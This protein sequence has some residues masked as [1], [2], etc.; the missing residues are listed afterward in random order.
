MIKLNN[1]AL[2]LIEKVEKNLKNEFDMIEQIN[3]KNQLKV[4]NAFIDNR[5]EARHFAGTTG[6][7]YDDAGRDAL[8][9]VCAAI[10]HTEDA[11]LSPSLSS[12]T[13]SISQ[14]LLAILRPNDTL[15]C[16]TGIPYD[17]LHDVI[18]GIDG[19]DIGS[20]KDYNIHFDYCDLKD[21][22]IDLVAVE[23]Y[24]K[25]KKP[26]A[27]YLQR[28]RGYCYRDAICIS[29]MREAFN[30]IKSLSPECIIIVDNCYGELTEEYEPT[31]VG[32]DLVI[33]SLIKNLGGGVAPSGGYVAGRKDLIEQIA[34][35]ITSPALGKETGSYDAGYRAYYQG[36]FIASNVVANAKKGALLSANVLREL[37]YNTLPAKN[38]TQSDIVTCIQFND[39]EKLIAFCRAIQHASPIDSS[40]M[41]TPSDMPG[42]DS[43]IIMASG[44]F[45]QGSSIEIS[46][47]APIREPYI[48]YLQGGLT[49]EHY[50]IAL[51][52]ALTETKLV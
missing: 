47:D 44:S 52:N 35:R 19:K 18:F 46:C 3:L 37:G 32:A 1:D 22:D 48:A 5:I 14:A 38:H 41:V 34:Y 10:F 21:N 12:G 2:N 31:D 51:Q 40:A 17:T 16:I 4:L 8:N 33:G 45:N 29:Q 28:S 6:Y 42:Y 27:V 23:K 36:L 30:L 25:S 7:G 39:K 24:I 20:L 13:Q 26:R 15:F 9:S 50:K 49:Y 11:I 43:K